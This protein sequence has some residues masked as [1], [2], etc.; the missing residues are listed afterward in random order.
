MKDFYQRRISILRD[1]LSLNNG[2]GFFSSTKE[3][4]LF[5]T[6]FNSSNSNLLITNKSEI[7]FTDKRYTQQ[8]K[9]LESKINTEFIEGNFTD[10]LRKYCDE[11]NIHK[12]YFDPSK[13]SVRKI[14][15]LRKII[16]L[17]FI[18]IRKDI[19]FIF[20]LQDEYSIKQTKKAIKVT[21][22]IFK[23]ILG[24]I[25]EGISEKDIKAELKYLIYKSADGEAFDPIVLF[26]KRTAFP[27]GVS[28]NNRLKVN[29]PILID[30]GVNV[31]GYNSDFTRTFY[32]GKPSDEF[33]NKYQIVLS[34]LRIGIEN[35]EANKKAQDVAISVIK[36]FERFNLDRNFTHALGHGLGVYLHNFPRLAL[37]SNQIIPDDIIV[38]IE[39]ALYFE[40]KFGIRIEQDILLYKGKKEILTKTTDELIV[41]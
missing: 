22:E 23:N 29:S 10:T 20:A 16:K 15:E 24:N 30:F 8:I 5:L 38:A 35:L 17:K 32:F 2:E 12:I 1:E 11:H 6:G 40:K 28:N 7:I 34:A 37:K 39:P 25:K 33:K 13:I 4:V 3:D 14:S 41:L 27:H 21:E 36:F 26:G 31:K 18:P 9:E 19:S